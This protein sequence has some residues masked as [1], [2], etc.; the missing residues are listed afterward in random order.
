M[1]RHD[2]KAVSPVVAIMLLLLITVVLGTTVYLVA[3]SFTSELNV[4]P[5][6]GLTQ[7]VGNLTTTT[8]L[9]A[10]V[11]QAN[12]HLSNFRTLLLVDDTSDPV[13]EI[14]PLNIG[15]HGSVTFTSIDAYL[16]SGDRFMVTFTP[17]HTYSLR[18]L[19]VNGGE[20]IQ[21]LDWTA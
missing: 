1:I 19:W 6:V 20:Q 15:T 14:N 11:S 12:I 3:T 7:L 5:Y 2:P 8:I 13:S 9:V 4:R 18:I 10:E 17:G 16:S 21:K